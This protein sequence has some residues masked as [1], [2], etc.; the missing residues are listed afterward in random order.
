[1]QC[2]VCPFVEIDYLLCLLDLETLWADKSWWITLQALNVFQPLAFVQ[3]SFFMVWQARVWKDAWHRNK[4]QLISQF[5]KVTSNLQIALISKRIKLLGRDWT[6]MEDFLRL[7]PDLTN[8][9]YLSFTKVRL[10]M[11]IGERRLML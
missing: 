4:P 11:F 10:F 3:S 9:P 6:Q 7:F 8:F 5:S 1:M 2:Y